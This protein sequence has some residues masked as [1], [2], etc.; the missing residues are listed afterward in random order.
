MLEEDLLELMFI[1]SFLSNIGNEMQWS[2]RY[3]D[4]V[5]RPGSGSSSATN[6]VHFI[7]KHA[8][9]LQSQAH[10]IMRL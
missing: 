10:S 6:K 1:Y 3:G 2:R 4:T 8:E 9:Y 7:H 5:W